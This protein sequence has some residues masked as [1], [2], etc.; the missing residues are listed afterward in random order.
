MRKKS[1]VIRPSGYSILYLGLCCLSIYLIKDSVTDLQ[2]EESYA[3]TSGI[4]YVEIA[5]KDRFPLMLE[6][7]SDSEPERLSELYSLPRKPVSGDRITIDDH[8][9][10]SLS[11]ISG[12][13]NL[14]LG[15]PIGI[16]S[17]SAADLVELPG[18]GPKLADRIIEH[19]NLN[20]NFHSVDELRQVRG[21][22]AKKLRHLR[23]LINL[24]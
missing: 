1:L 8:G 22:G 14:T 4:V 23:Q 16:N 15:V 13:K 7:R 11:R 20:S 18:I 21:I 9:S 17:A 5:E 2:Y 24:D 10:A 19:R 3:T 6:L 12:K